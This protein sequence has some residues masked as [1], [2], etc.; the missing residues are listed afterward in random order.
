MRSLCC[1]IALS[2]RVFA[3]DKKPSLEEKVKDSTPLAL[4]A[5][6]A[7]KGDAIFQVTPIHMEKPFVSDWFA[8]GPRSLRVDGDKLQ[9]WFKSRDGGDTVHAFKLPKGKGKLTY[10]AG[11]G[12]KGVQPY[13]R[14]KGNYKSREDFGD[15]GDSIISRPLGAAI[16]KPN[17]EEEDKGDQLRVEDLEGKE[18]AKLGFVEEKNKICWLAN[19]CSY[20]NIVFLLDGNCR[21]IG[22]WSINGKHLFNSECR[23]LGMDYPWV[24]AM[25]VTDKGEHYLGF[26]QKRAKGDGKGRSNIQ[27]AAFVKIT[28]PDTIKAN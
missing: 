4:E 8:D 26:T 13:D 1:L 19:Y 28:G 20:K 9:A 21:K 5:Q 6:V 16:G 23:E 11:F 18:L 3:D 24:Q 7:K 12:D 2:S 17:K 14:K 22:V 10:D 25:D 27:E 15:W